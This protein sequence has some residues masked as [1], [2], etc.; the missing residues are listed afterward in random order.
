MHASMHN[1]LSH[2]RDCRITRVTAH[3]KAET[4]HPIVDLLMKLLQARK[5]QPQT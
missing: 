2:D 1:P 3:A 5:T 4:P